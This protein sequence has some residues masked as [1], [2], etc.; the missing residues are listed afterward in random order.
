M[1]EV[2][3]YRDVRK[4]FPARLYKP[5]FIVRGT[6]DYLGIIFAELDAAP[7]GE[8]TTGIIEFLYEGIDYSKLISGVD[9]I[10]KEGAVEVGKGIIL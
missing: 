5:H 10:I 8:Y 1:V 4:T 6:D 2:M 9:F 3:F 7:F